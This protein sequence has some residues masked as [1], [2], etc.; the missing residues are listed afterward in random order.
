PRGSPGIFYE[1]KPNVRGRFMGQ[2]LLINSQG[3]RDYEYTR[4]KEPGTFRLVGVGDSSLFGWGVPMEDGGLKVLE[5]RLNEKS[6]ARKFEIINSA[7][8]GYNTAMES[9]TFVQ[10]CLEY[11]PDLVLLNFNTNDYD[12][13]QFMRRPIDLATLR[14]SYL[15]DLAYSV[16]D[17]VTAAEREP[18][19]LF[20]FRHRTVAEREAA[21]LDEDPAVP[22]E[23]RYMVGAK[24]V[25]RALERLAA[26]ARERAIPFVVFDVKP[27]PGLDPNYER[28]ELRDG[29]RELL[30]RE[31]R[32]LGFY[33]LNTYPY[34][35]DY[36]KQHPDASSR[37][38][39]AVSP[40]DNHAKALAH[41]INAQQHVDYLV[42]HQL[43]PS[44]KPS[45]DDH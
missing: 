11:A 3:L 28:D 33:F 5:R 7:V 32:R 13:P 16:Y 24:G 18:L 38:V 19:L 8:P 25:V 4:R 12:V 2:P 30:E 14:K 41:S 21:R 9:E 43:L 36:L 1:L 22:D 10:K 44:D 34:F 31:S 20:D 39:F 26:A 29:Q 45:K 15:F 6:R 42:A 27:Y 35:V 17:G 23:Y 37:P 40:V